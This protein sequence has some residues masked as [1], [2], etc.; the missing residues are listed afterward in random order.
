MDCQV[1]MM[2]EQNACLH[3][4]QTSWLDYFHTLSKLSCCPHQL[5]FLYLYVLCVLLILEMVVDSSSSR[6]RR[7][8][9]I[10]NIDCWD[11]YIAIILVHYLAKQNSING[12]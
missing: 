11:Q 12:E 6:R 5:L 4:L 7:Q 2:Y 3:T 1:Y 8:T 10:G 9:S